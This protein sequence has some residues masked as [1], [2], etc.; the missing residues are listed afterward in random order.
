MTDPNDNF[1]PFYNDYFPPQYG[2]WSYGL[3]YDD[4]EFRAGNPF[5]DVP[6]MEHNGWIFS[7]QLN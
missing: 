1:H 7:I 5:S 4:D 2:P 6:E 3:D